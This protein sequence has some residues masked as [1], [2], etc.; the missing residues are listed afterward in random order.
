MTMDNLGARQAAIKLDGWF[1]KENPAPSHGETREDGRGKEAPPHHIL[2]KAP[3][4][5][6]GQ[7]YLHE[8]GLWLDETLATIIVDDELRKALKKALMS[9]IHESYQNGRNS[10]LAPT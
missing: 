1:P 5:A 9:K 8:T 2:V 4:P 10:S 3:V 6:K 7:G